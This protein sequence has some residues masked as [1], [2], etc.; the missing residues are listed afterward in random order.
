MRYLIIGGAGFIG[1][2]YSKFLLENGHDVTIFDNLSRLT[3]RKNIEY[4][5]S[6]FDH[7]KFIYG[8]IRSDI[9]SLQRCIEN[10]DVI[11]NL[12]AQV[13]VTTS[14]VD[15]RSDFE[16]NLLGT[17]NLLELIRKFNPTIKFIFASTN[18]VY[19]NLEA[20]NII[21]TEHSYKF[22]DSIVG[23]NEHFP[24]DFYSPYGCSKG[25]ADQYVIDYSRCYGLNTT[26]V[27]QSCI[28]G[29]MQYGVEDQGWVAWF[30]IAAMR[31]QLITIYGNGKQVRDIL[32]CDDLINLYEKIVSNSSKSKG[33]IY[34]AGGGIKNSISLLNLIEIL[35][36]KLNRKIDT[37]FSDT[38][39]GDQK[40][41]I[42]DNSKSTI[43]LGWKP[44]TNFNQGLDFMIS[45]LKENNIT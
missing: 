40:I 13:A 17:F 7:L 35:E 14:I 12:A 15:P 31:K 9:Y 23:I 16:I 1:S 25:A 3:A 29:R 5:I 19:G 26:V 43:E 44:Q 27:R 39:L 4:L 45:W 42:S 2:N 24:L 36:K 21:E 38:R 41:F 22:R 34:N 6:N 11:V 33:Q 18:K 28:F 37:N 10:S 32:F 20:L 30:T 8:D